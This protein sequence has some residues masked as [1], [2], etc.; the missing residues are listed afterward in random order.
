[1]ASDVFMKR[2][3]QL[4]F[5]NVMEDARLRK[6]VNFN[7]IY[8]LNPSTPPYIWTLAPDL[9]PTD[10]LKKISADAEAVPT[11]LWFDHES[12]QQTLIVCGQCTAVY[13]LLKF[14][15]E[16]WQDG[17]EGSPAPV[18]K[19]D[20]PASPYYDTYMKLKAVWDK[21]KADPNAFLDRPRT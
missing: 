17:Q 11:T 20:D 4:E 13:S 16:R 3:R 15:W 19:P 9:V 6:Q 18:P 1:M 21:L 8:D 10:E 7:L 12:D 14:L 5:E 2:I